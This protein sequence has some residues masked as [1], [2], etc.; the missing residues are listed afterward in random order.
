MA[1]FLNSVTPNPSPKIRDGQDLSTRYTGPEAKNVSVLISE[2][3][4]AR[5]TETPE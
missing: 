2:E 5:S 4:S 3:G 1:I